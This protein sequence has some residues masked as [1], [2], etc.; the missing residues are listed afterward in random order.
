MQE[1]KKGENEN[2]YN[3]NIGNKMESFLP[4][5]DLAYKNTTD[6]DPE[7]IP[8]GSKFLKQWKG[9][10]AHQYCDYFVDQKSRDAS[11]N[12]SILL[13]LIERNDN[14]SDNSFPNNKEQKGDLFTI[15][16]RMYGFR[17]DLWQTDS[18]KSL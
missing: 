18:S 11:S 2:K 3:K 8:H 7:R 17:C 1:N 12:S 16:Y 9:L 14:S 6:F 13:L 4:F 10:L 15:F 5:I